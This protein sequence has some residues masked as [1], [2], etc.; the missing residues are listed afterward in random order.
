MLIGANVPKAQVHAEYRRGR[1]GEPHAV[2][3]GLGWA[4]LGPVNVANRSS[5]QVVNVK[6]VKYDDEL[7]DQQI[8]QFLRLAMQQGV[9]LD[10]QLHQG[11]DLT[12]SLLGFL[13]RFRQYPR[14][15]I[16]V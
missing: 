5:S 1:S 11:P 6:F 3:T 4:V 8:R 7:P 14:F 9:S 16:E 2:R 10:N 13:L 15:S 12:N